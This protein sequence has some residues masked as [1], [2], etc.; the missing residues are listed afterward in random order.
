MLPS[1]DLFTVDSLPLSEESVSKKKSF[2]TLAPGGAERT[3]RSICQQFRRTD[4]AEVKNYQ[5]N[6]SGVG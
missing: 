5:T 6:Y 4:E 1:S 3:E 2:I